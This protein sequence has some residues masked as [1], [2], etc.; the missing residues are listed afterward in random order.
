[1]KKLFFLF[2]TVV[3]VLNASAQE[4]NSSQSQSVEISIDSLSFKVNKLQHDYDFMYCDYELHKLLM[5]LKDMSHTVDNAANGVLINFYNSRYDRALYNTY[6]DHYD[7]LCALFDS[8][9]REIEAAQIAVGVK[10]MSA[11][12][13]DTELNVLSAR[14]NTI[15]KAIAT[16]EK[17]LEYY[18]VAIKAYRSKR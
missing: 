17:S 7:A 13:T 6:L 12:F 5:D 14:F 9:K 4:I 2:V 10:V 18:N 16:A 3:G 15:D 1:M 11:S 8:L